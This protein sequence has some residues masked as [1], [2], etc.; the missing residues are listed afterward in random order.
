M[1]KNHHEIIICGAG[2]IGLTFALLMAEKKI[3]VCIIDKNDK[4]LLFTQQDNRTT[5]ISQ[6]SYR[7]YRKLG[8]WKKLRNEFQPINQIFVSEGLGS[9]DINFDQ[10]N[11]KEGSLG[12][13]VD[14]NLIKRILLNEVSK[15]KY[16]S[17]KHCTEVFD[18]HNE[19]IDNSFIET[20]DFKLY[21]KMLVAADGRFS[22]TRY[23]ANMKYYFHDYH[24][25]AF[26]FNISHSKKHHGVALERF[27]PTGPLAILPVKNLKINQSSIVWTVDSA[28]ANDDTF[29]KNF[30][31]EFEKKYDNFFG[32]LISLSEV[33]EY[34]LNV[35][36]CYD[37]F[38]K[39]VVLIGDACQAI[40]PIAGQGFNLGLRDAFILAETLE[41]SM[42]LGLEPF[43]LNLMKSYENM[44]KIDK[45]L[46]V[47]ST[48]NLN[49]LFS[50]S[51]RFKSLFRKAGLRIF[52][53]S[54]FLKN[55]SMLFAM[56]LRNLEV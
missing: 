39:N 14:N 6:G 18:I 13:I 3:R 41:K 50:G 53:Q 56:G 33:K 29:K 36:S 51:G 23:H 8:I 47:N 35:F 11:L 12:F 15:S 16:I 44:R 30:R 31:K 48:H 34:S 21:F 4:K 49:S 43:N 19:D 5:A 52:S 17:F 38:K 37:I 32:K 10:K 46:L 40:H 2:M 25:T 26:V 9:H 54:T 20:K 24:Q 1:T 22:R 45:T 42:E 28:V 55:Q 7:I 27:F